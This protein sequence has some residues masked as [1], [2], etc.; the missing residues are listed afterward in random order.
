ML[1]DLMPSS[2]HRLGLDKTKTPGVESAP[3]PWRFVVFEGT[4]VRLSIDKLLNF[5]VPLH[6]ECR[7]GRFEPA[8]N[9]GPIG[10]IDSALAKC[11]GQESRRFAIQGEH[12]DPRGRPIQAVHGVNFLAQPRLKDIGQGRFAPVHRAGVNVQA[13]RLID[14][15]QAVVSVDHK[16]GD[17]ENVQ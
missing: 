3:G 10:F 8:T 5:G 13:C 16:R 12:K 4:K 7:I 14:R 15:D 1:T 6:G 9:N 11:C 2:G 17:I